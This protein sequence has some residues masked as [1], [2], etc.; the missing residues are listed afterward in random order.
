[1]VE[2]CHN[3]SI[4]HRSIHYIQSTSTSTNIYYSSITKVYFAIKTIMHIVRFR[5]FRKYYI[6]IYIVLHRKNEMKLHSAPQVN[7][8][9]K[10][11]IDETL[12]CF[13]SIF[14]IV[15][16]FKWRFLMLRI[17]QLQPLNWKVFQHN[18]SI[19]LKAFQVLLLNMNNRKI[20]KKL[21]LTE[22]VNLKR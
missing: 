14:L 8:A 20:H 5:S 21:N 19:S 7:C 10:W 16:D 1:M 3:S 13:N 17:S 9:L 12:T 15:R 11:L 2:W 18:F 4:V 6:H 22:K